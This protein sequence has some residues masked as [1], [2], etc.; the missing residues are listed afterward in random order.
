MYSD[1]VCYSVKKKA[2][3]GTSAATYNGVTLLAS[4]LL[5]LAGKWFSVGKKPAF[6]HL[7]PS[8]LST[9]AAASETTKQN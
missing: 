9:W 4:F 2:K 8:D 3:T 1:F 6:C 7:T 5:V